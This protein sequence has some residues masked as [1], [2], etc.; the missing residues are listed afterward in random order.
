MSIDDNQLM[1]ECQLALGITQKEMGALLDKDRRTIQRWQ[2]TGCRMLP[3]D[4]EKLANA[5]RPVRPDL[6]EAVLAL[7]EKTA[8]QAGLPGPVAAASAE[9]VQGIIDAAAA[10]ADLSPETMR[11]AVRA[12]FVRAMEADVDV[13]AVVAAMNGGIVEETDPEG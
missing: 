5:V 8:R 6:A 11:G 13:R 10:A 4:A 1:I 3:A 2:D 9:V 7:G 12:A